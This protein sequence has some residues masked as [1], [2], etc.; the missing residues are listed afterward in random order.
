LQKSDYGIAI[1]FVNAVTSWIVGSTVMYVSLA[2]CHHLEL[3]GLVI[4]SPLI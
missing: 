2:R 4:E 1:I 3:L